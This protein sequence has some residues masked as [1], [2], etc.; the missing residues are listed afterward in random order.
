M[1]IALNERREWYGYVKDGEEA[2]MIY[3][4]LLLQ[5]LHVRAKEHNEK[6]QAE[7]KMGICEICL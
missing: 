6:P 5:H 4:T 3:F 2:F 1:Y 7:I